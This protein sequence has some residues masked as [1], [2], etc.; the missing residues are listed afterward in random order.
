MTYG[1]LAVG[2]TP[3]S[4]RHLCVWHVRHLRALSKAPVHLHFE[5]TAELLSRLKAPAIPEFLL[6]LANRRLRNAEPAFE[7]MLHRGIR[8]LQTHRQPGSLL[9]AE[10]ADPVPCPTCGMYF[11]SLATM[12]LHRARK[13]GASLQVTARSEPTKVHEVQLADHYL[14]GV[15]TCRHCGA[16]YSRRQAFRNHI[17]NTCYLSGA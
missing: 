7:R 6:K 4:L 17:L 10:H 16:V 9:S 2:I 12:R 8:I 3:A 13:H 15:P 5:P 14:G 1:I 11:S